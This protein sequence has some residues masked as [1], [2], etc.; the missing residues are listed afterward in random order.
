MR[1]MLVTMDYPPPMGGIQVV[2]K[3]LEDDLA[4]AGYEVCVV[5]FDGRNTSNYRK[6]ALRDLFSS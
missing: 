6:V 1:I 4:L 5:S 3:N 2:A